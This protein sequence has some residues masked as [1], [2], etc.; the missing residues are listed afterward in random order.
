[1]G[2]GGEMVAGSKLK[3]IGT[4]H[5]IRSNTGATNQV[6]FTAL[7][8]GYRYGYSGTFDSVGSSGFWW[9]ATELD[10]YYAWGRPLY[11]FDSVVYR[12]DYYKPSG[13]SVRL[14]RD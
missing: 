11:Y 13:F 5:W 14:V 12:Y 9:S 2:L 3:E 7:P 8:G 10:S 1:M 4:T 6:G